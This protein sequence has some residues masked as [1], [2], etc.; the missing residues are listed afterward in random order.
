MVTAVMVS[1]LQYWCTHGCKL[2][3]LNY[4]KIKLYVYEARGMLWIW[5]KFNASMDE[6]Y[7]CMLKLIWQDLGV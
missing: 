1:L 3:D 7:V 4:M 6:E 2:S 5:G